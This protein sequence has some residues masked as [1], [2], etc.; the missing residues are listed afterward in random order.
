VPGAPWFKV[1]GGDGGSS[2]VHPTAPQ[3]LYVT[4]QWGSQV[5]YRATDGLDFETIRPPDLGHSQR[6]QFLPPMALDGFDGSRL[7]LGTDRVFESRNGGD[8]WSTAGTPRL[9]PP[10]TFSAVAFAPGLA[11]VAYA[12]GFGNLFVRVGESWSEM[13]VPW[14]TSHHVTDLEVSPHNALH[15]FVAAG[16]NDFRVASTPDGGATWLDHTGNLPLTFV[17][18]LAVDWEA[19]TIWAATDAGVFASAIGSGTWRDASLGL[20]R[21]AVMDLV[22]D[23][24]AGALVAATHGR[25]AFVRPLRSP[26]GR[27]L[28]LDGGRFHVAVEWETPRGDRGGGVARRLTEDTGAFWFFHQDNVELVVKVLDACAGFDRFWVFA[29]GLT[30]VGVT[31]RVTDLLTGRQRAYQSPG[32]TAFQPILDSDAFASCYTRGMEREPAPAVVAASPRPAAASGDTLELGR[33]RFRV[34]AEWRTADG[35]HGAGRAVPLTDDTGTLWFFAPDNVEMVVKV[36]DGCAVN[37][38]FW[39]FAGGLTDVAVEWTVTDTVAGVSRRYESPLGA[40]FAP[41]QDTRAFA[42]CAPATAE[43]GS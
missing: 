6:S 42:T 12:G 24:A 23:P 15:L 8:D 2:A 13:P 32:G 36:L 35:G 22:I 7:L 9:P 38:A 31:L 30:D 33:G 18:A 29:A 41:L 14:R 39:V 25:G 20:P 26:P 16:V 3:T 19:G 10:G 17:N 27:P 1:F 5:I 21:V 37:G 28:R 11:D 40:P 43:A 4:A 34:S